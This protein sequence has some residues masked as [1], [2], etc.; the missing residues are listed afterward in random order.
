[1]PF[2]TK[3]KIISSTFIRKKIRKGQIEEVNKLLNRN[4]SIRG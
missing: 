2:K 3:R 4:W 1:M